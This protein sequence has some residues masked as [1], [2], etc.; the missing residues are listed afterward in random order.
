MRIHVEVLA[1]IT[2][3]WGNWMK[4][5]INKYVDRLVT[6]MTNEGKKERKQFGEWTRFD[7][8]NEN[9]S[10]KPDQQQQQHQ[11]RA[12]ELNDLNIKSTACNKI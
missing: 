10:I 2:Y 7:A 11:W 8:E 1:F 4:Q 9:D 6:Q 5:V 3:V 12:D